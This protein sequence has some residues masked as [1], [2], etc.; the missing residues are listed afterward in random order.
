MEFD[1]YDASSPLTFS[2]ELIFTISA[3]VDEFCKAANSKNRDAGRKVRKMEFNIHRLNQFW[4][5]GCI[6][7][8]HKD[9]LVISCFLFFN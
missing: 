6:S 7:K 1:F 3:T 9:V 2:I 4:K 8:V 5:G